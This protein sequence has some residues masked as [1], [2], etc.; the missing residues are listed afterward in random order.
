MI[1]IQSLFIQVKS[2]V[3]TIRA[4]KSGHIHVTVSKKRF[5]ELSEEARMSCVYAD[6]FIYDTVAK[7]LNFVLTEHGQ[8]RLDQYHPLTTERFIRV[9]LWPRFKGKSGIGFSVSQ[10]AEGI[11]IFVNKRMHEK[12]MKMAADNSLKDPAEVVMQIIIKD[13]ETLTK[14]AA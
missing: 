10:D 6:R 3:A 14:E 9:V 7:D 4:E 1:R 2:G 8:Q 13:L 5:K 12:L 11:I